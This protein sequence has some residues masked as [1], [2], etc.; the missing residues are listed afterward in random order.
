MEKCKQC[1]IKFKILRNQHNQIIYFCATNS[2]K[3]L[4][5]NPK[6]KKEKDD[7]KIIRR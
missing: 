3:V 7:F 4:S 5:V 1:G 2:C 6:I